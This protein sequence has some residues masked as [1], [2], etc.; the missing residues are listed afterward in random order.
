[1]KSKYIIR[2]ITLLLCYVFI[3]TSCNDEWKEEQYKQYIS[4]RAPLGELGVT[5][6]Y[7]PY[8]RRN[9]DKTFVK[10]SGLSSYQLPIIVSGSTTNDKDITVHI[11]HDSDTLKVL[12]EARFLQQSKLWYTDIKDYTT[13]PEN[14]KILAKENIGLANIEFNFNGIDMSHKWLLPLTIVDGATYNYTA[15]LRKNYAKALL[16]IFP[17][18]D[19]SGDYSGSTLKIFVTGEEAN[20]TAKSIIRS[21]VVDENTIF[22]YA[23]DIDEN[24]TDRAMYKI[25][26]RF[27]GVKE[28][29]VDLYTD[30]PNLKFKVNKQAS[31]H[32]IEQKDDVRPYLKHRYVIINNINYNYVDYTSSPGSE[33]KWSVNGTLTLERQINTQIP[34]EDQAI[35][36]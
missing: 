6:V 26:A 28:G 35:E 3:L 22:F 14:I 21:Y 17:F 8:S 23:G 11:A 32:I 15:H 1:M 20:A 10:G 30:N 34:D 5:D 19:Y 27:N 4:F 2:L 36:W 31:F 16:R 29:T 24:R 9:P 33:F 25:Y 7:I 18:N 12:N 13:I